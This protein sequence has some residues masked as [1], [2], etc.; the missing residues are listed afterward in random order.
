MRARARGIHRVLPRKTA[1][2]KL[3][4]AEF[5]ETDVCEG[6]ADTPSYVYEAS[7]GVL[8]QRGC[9][10]NYLCVRRMKCFA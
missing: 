6:A 1:E 10:G 3:G 2:G 9:E 4:A 8:T 5:Q 7:T